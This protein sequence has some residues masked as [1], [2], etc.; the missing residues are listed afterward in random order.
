MKSQRNHTTN[1]KIGSERSFGNRF[2]YGHKWTKFR[3]RYIRENPYCEH[4]RR[5]GKIR[6]AQQVH[7]IIE[8]IKGGSLLDPENVESIC[9]ECHI[10]HHRK[11]RVKNS[12]KYQTRPCLK[13]G[14][15]KIRQDECKE[16]YCEFIN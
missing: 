8:V 14:L 13:C 2:V 6:I 11:V 3:N 7:H 12:K 4:C 10:K 15:P 16:K 9:E 5:K 1:S